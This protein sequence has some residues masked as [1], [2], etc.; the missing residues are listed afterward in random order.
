LVALADGHGSSVHAEIGA[1]LAVEVAVAALVAF[2]HDLGRSIAPTCGGASF[3]QDPLRV[4][5]VRE[6]AEAV[7]EVG[8]A[9]V[10]LMD[11]GSTL[12]FAVVTPDCSCS[13]S[14]ATG[15]SS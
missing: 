12:L 1:R 9:D 6:W 7:R 15:T 10:E 2:R 8:G 5:L 14:S 4:Q 11:Y 13:A 3:A